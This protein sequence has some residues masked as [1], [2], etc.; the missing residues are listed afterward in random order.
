LD[1][2]R[3]GKLVPLGDTEAMA[4]AILR[5]L[6]RPPSPELLRDAAKRFFCD[7]IAAEY[8]TLP[9]FVP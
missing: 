3:Y 2:G 5:T 6:D 4:E 8:L 1:H 9:A 7:H